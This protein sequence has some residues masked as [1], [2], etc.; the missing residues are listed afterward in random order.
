MEAGGPNWEVTTEDVD[1][2]VA[3]W[4]E[5][6]YPAPGS[7]V[8]TVKFK[9]DI[10]LELIAREAPKCK[11]GLTDGEICRDCISEIFEGLQT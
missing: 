11:H 10:E 8:F 3:V 1:I 6:G 2:A 7:A 5:A 4:R 9:G